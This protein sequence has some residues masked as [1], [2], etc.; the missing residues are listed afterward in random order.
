MHNLGMT[1]LSVL[2]PLDQPLGKSRLLWGLREGLVHPGFRRLRICVAFANSGPLLR[3]GSEI[4]AWR[5]AGKRIEAIFGVDLGGTSRQALDLALTSFD[6]VYYTQ[7]RGLTF[8]PKIYLFESDDEA[9]CFVGSN[10]LTVGGTETNFEAALRLDMALPSDADTLADLTKAWEDLLPGTCPATTRLTAAALA[11][12]SADEVVYDERSRGG[13]DWITSRS[14]I[15]TKVMARRSALRTRPP[16]ALPPGVH[17][18]RR[19]TRSPGIVV[20]PPPR[21]RVV[22]RGFCPSDKTT[23]QRGD[24][25]E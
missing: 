20:A 19:S 6:T 18:G 22:P 25:L 14:G 16:S 1:R 13:A 9:L 2:A 5:A 23:R 11:Q 7:H 3:L 12:L 17:G 15:S 8:H 10:N 21:S 4:A 24:I